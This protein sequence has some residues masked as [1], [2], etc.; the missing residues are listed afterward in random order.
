MITGTKEKCLG[1]NILVVGDSSDLPALYEKLRQPHYN[2]HHAKNPQQA[3][4]ILRQSRMEF[5]LVLLD[6]VRPRGLEEKDDRGALTSNVALL[7]L[8]RLEYPTAHI[9]LMWGHSRAELEQC[10]LGHLAHTFLFLH[11][12]GSRRAVLHAVENALQ[13][14][15]LTYEPIRGW[16][17]LARTA[18]NAWESAKGESAVSQPMPIHLAPRV[19]SRHV[20]SHAL[21]RL[22]L[23]V[24]QLFHGLI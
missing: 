15:S 5:K 23:F 20:H 21:S 10:G 1:P 14:P 24:C 16:E 19:S 22:T 18:V 13:S 2:L 11:K 3:L 9:L 4:I 12:A 6:L 7:P 17:N 8:V